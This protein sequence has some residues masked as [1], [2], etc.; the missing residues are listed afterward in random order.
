MITL[1]SKVGLFPVDVSNYF[2]LSWL[3]TTPTIILIALTAW[4]RALVVTMSLNIIPSYHHNFDNGNI[5][6]IRDEE[7]RAR[8]VAAEA[9]RQ[10]RILS[11]API[12]WP[13]LRAEQQRQQLAF[14]WE[15]ID[16]R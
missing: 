5:Q 10:Y 8:R 11:R 16:P 9:Y 6:I 2:S 1:L 15:Q 4:R 14:L 12:I 3:P 7:A 13:P